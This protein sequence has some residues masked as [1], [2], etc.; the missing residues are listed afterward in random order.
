MWKDGFEKPRG[1]QSLQILGVNF[2]EV[3]Y[4]K[5]LLSNI[6]IK[7]FKLINRKKCRGFVYS[8]G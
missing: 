4:L 5:K 1:T 2:P 3:Q 7:Y 6:Q 8:L